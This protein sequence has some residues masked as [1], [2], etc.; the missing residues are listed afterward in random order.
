MSPKEDRPRFSIP[1][2]TGLFLRP[3]GVNV[4]G[5]RLCSLLFL[6]G[7]RNL[8][9]C[10]SGPILQPLPCGFVIILG[11]YI[12]LPLVMGLTIWLTLANGMLTNV[13]WP[14]AWKSLAWLAFSL[15]ALLLHAPASQLAPERGWETCGTGPNCPSEPS[16]YQPTARF[17]VSSAK[18][19]KAT[20]PRSASFSQPS[21]NLQVCKNKYL[22]Y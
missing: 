6:K 10:I 4:H 13:L 3:T 19:N 20:Q 5:K 7:G 21:I 12:S 22:H 11:E 17:W 14:K 15:V 9:A 8:V 16:F 2:E 18:N 1:Q